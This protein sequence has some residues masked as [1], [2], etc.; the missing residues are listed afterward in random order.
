[1]KCSYMQNHE[2]IK[3]QN[4]CA[5]KAHQS[6]V[7]EPNSEEDQSTLCLIGY[8]TSRKELRDVYYSI[9]SLNR[10]P[11]FPSCG[12]VKRMRAI[13]EI[14]SLLQERL[15]RQTPSTEAK[16]IPEHKMGSIPLPTYEAA[17]QDVHCKVIQT[18]ASLQDDLN[19]LDNE[20]QGRSQTH[21]P[22]ITW[23]RM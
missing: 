6:C 21:S 18:A 7:T 13:W 12:K 10:A 17:L 16:D 14:L 23:H 2:G 5:T 9:Y 15:Q 22:S 11:G 4:A 8:H 1:M 3:R 19:R 20:L